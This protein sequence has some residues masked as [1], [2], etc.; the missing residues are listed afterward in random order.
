[1]MGVAFAL[2]FAYMRCFFFDVGFGHARQGFA[3]D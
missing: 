2:T 1:L 3:S